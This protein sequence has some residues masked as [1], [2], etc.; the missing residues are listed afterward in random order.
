MASI[1]LFIGNNDIRLDAIIMLY[2]LWIFVDDLYSILKVLNKWDLQ[3][4]AVWNYFSYYTCI[5]YIRFL[6]YHTN[7]MLK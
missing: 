7:E 4:K 2:L 1:T 6:Q 3:M 5:C